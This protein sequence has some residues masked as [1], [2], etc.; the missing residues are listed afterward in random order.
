MS[1]QAGFVA[2]EGGNYICSLSQR[3]GLVQL[4]PIREFHIT[5][6]RLTNSQVPNF[7]QYEGYVNESSFL[8]CPSETLLFETGEIDHS[9]VA[10]YDNPCRFRISCCLRQRL[11]VPR[12]G[13]NANQPMGWNHE[14]NHMV[15]PASTGPAGAQGPGWYRVKMKDLSDRYPT[16]DFTNIFN[17]G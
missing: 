16:K 11:I 14:Y 17:G 1:A 4:I 5:L 9:F 8:G 12:V 10:D 15:P 7:Q 3:T 6:D 13:H 2:T